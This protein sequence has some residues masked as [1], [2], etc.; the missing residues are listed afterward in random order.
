M[1]PAKTILITG[2]CGYIGSHVVRQLSS[3]GHHVVVLDNLSTG[4]PSALL[5]HEDLFVGDVGDEDLLGKILTTRKFDAIMHFAAAIVVPESVSKPALYYR[6]NTMNALR[7]FDAAARYQVAHVVFSSTAAVYGEKTKMPVTESDSLEPT[8]P[9]GSSKMMSERILQDIAAATGLRYVALRYFNVAG[10]DPLSRIGQRSA[11]ATHLIKI[12]C[13]V[14]TGK[15]DQVQ[16]F[17]Q[18]YPTRDGTCIRDYVHV[19]DLADAHVEALNYLDRG[20]ASTIVNCGYG[21]GSSVLEVIAS[22]EKAAKK[23]LKSTL[24]PRRPGD[25]AELIAGPE[26]IRN[27][28]AWRPRY[29]DLDQI[30]AHALAWE[31]TGFKR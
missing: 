16:I 19:E 9:Y 26:K 29:D 1:T 15:R 12:C 23:K 6:N 21:R 28:F 4:Y 31:A 22:V 18:D 30:T 8:N 10:A 7:L 5:N 13:E 27:L 17:G 2:G 14:A 25:V 24:A 20:G 11:N 3:L